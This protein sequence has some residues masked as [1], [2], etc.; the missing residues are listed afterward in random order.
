MSD[1]SKTIEE[2]T[3]IPEIDVLD[4]IPGFRKARIKKT[5]EDIAG[6]VPEDIRLPLVRVLVGKV[7]ASLFRR[8][9]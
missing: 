3:G 6:E 1:L 2:L 7:L 5:A 9:G 8:A 4:R